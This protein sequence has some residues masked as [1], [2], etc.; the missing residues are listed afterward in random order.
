M[1]GHPEQRL[2]I[3]RL[4]ILVDP[5]GTPVRVA[6][7]LDFGHAV[8][9][10]LRVHHVPH[11]RQ[12]QKCVIGVQRGCHLREALHVCKHLQNMRPRFRK[13]GLDLPV[14]AGGPLRSVCLTH[15]S[16]LDALYDMRGHEMLGDAAHAGEQDVRARLHAEALAL[17][18]I[19]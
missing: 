13:R 14:I 1:E 2:S 4:C 17:D 6:N 12:E 15:A 19:P 8:A 16:C 10:T 18:G 3:A 7:G 5:H 9:L 11:L